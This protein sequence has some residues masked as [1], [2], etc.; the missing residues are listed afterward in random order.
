[1]DEAGTVLEV[2]ITGTTEELTGEELEFQYLHE[3]ELIRL[4][5][6]DEGT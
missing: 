6:E 2:G 4:Y 1:M 5:F 3:D